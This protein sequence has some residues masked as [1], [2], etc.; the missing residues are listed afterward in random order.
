MMKKMNS[1]KRSPLALAV[2]SASMVMCAA[3][4]THAIEFYDIAGVNELSGS[5]GVTLSYATGVRTENSDKSDLNPGFTSGGLNYAAEGRVPDK[6]DMTSNVARLSLESS[7][8]WRNYGFVGYGTYQY[9]SEIMD[10]N[11]INPL[12]GTERD[13]IDAAK[14]YSGNYFDVPEAYV[15]ASYDFGDTP[16]DIRLGRQVIN[17]GEGLFFQNGIAVQSPLNFNKL[18]TPGADLKEALIGVTSGYAQIGVGDYSSIEIYAQTEWRR[19]ELPPVGTFYG[20]DVLGRGGEEILPNSE[21]LG[22]LA[23]READITASDSGQW[24]ISFRTLL[25]DTEYGVYYSRHHETR[26]FAAATGVGLEAAAAYSIAPTSVLGLAQIWPEDIDMLGLSA[27]TTF[28]NWSVNGEMAFRPDQPL[29]GDIIQKGYVNADMNNIEKH[30]TVHASVHGI[31]LG[32][33]LPGGIDKQVFLI[34]AG[35]DHIEGD[36]ANLSAQ[37][38]I[39]RN[40]NMAT[41]TP[42]N[43]S[44]G[45]ALQYDLTWQAITAG[46]DLTFGMFL[47]KD[48]KG[49]SHFWGN[50]AQDRLLG[51]FSLAANIGNETE[52]KLSY[53]MTQQSNSDTSDLDTV[54]LSVNY[55]F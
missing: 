52:A 4:T 18:V 2:L 14:D 17:W 55:K 30:D 26:P 20:S 53:A 29:F 45:V 54:N 43:T 6:G 5:L 11:A 42:D 1:L 31:W 10:D 15:Y 48:M 21:M 16:V 32:A 35:I 49:N 24:G 46:T 51:A 9:D 25:G 38:S 28:G 39:T 36:T 3:S 47:Q 19:S 33:S 22:N 40:E 50:F 13:S 8:N 44:Y 41:L 12:D 34:Q 7:M 23:T 37:Q 27:A